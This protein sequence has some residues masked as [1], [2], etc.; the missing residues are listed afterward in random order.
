MKIIKIIIKI[1]LL[2]FYL[3]VNANNKNTFSYRNKSGETSTQLCPINPEDCLRICR[4][5]R[6]CGGF[7][8]PVSTGA[9]E[10]HCYNECFK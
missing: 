8:N 2:L 1:F 10:A 5:L 4:H 3:Y 7:D 6:E 9:C